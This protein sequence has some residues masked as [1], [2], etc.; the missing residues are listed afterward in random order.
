M[1]SSHLLQLSC[2][3]EKRFFVLHWISTLKKKASFIVKYT[4]G[5]SKCGGARSDLW[6]KRK[7][8]MRF[9]MTD[10]VFLTFVG[11]VWKKRNIVQFVG[12]FLRST[13]SFSDKNLKKKR[14]SYS[15]YAFSFFLKCL[16]VFVSLK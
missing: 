8:D 2:M 4:V 11:T 12:I 13:R 5:S 3:L 7:S 15:R 1:I 14:T 6:C 9:P 16:C 10:R